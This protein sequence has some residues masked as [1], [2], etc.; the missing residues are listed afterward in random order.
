MLARVRVAAGA[1]LLFTTACAKT[2]RASIANTAAIHASQDSIFRAVRSTRRALIRRFV[3]TLDGRPSE[4]RP[5][6]SGKWR[7]AAGRRRC[8]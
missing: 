1:A 7:L 3:L 2:D 8:G 6:S 5:K 4:Q